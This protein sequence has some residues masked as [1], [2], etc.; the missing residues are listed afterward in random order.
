MI[1]TTIGVLLAELAPNQIS[2]LFTEDTT[3][4][5]IAQNGFKISMMFFTVVGAQIIIQNFFQSIGSPNISIF[6]SLTR[7]LL[8]LIPTLLVLPAWLGINGVWLSLAVSDMLAFIVAAITLVILLKR[9]DKHFS[10]LNIN[11]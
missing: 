7:Q 11:S 4:I 6:L 9:Q 5:D 2:A 3:L 10:S 8:F 1:I